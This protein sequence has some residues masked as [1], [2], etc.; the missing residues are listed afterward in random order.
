LHCASD[1][2]KNGILLTT[3]F[4]RIFSDKTGP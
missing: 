3:D 1:K 4:M 2:G